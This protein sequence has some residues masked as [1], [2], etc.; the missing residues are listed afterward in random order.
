MNAQAKGLSVE[1]PMLYD[2]S[3]S[4]LS[5]SYQYLVTQIKGHVPAV[6]CNSK[7]PPPRM[8]R[9]AERKSKANDP[10][11]RLLGVRYD[12]Q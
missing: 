1:Q 3:I 2:T 4:I 12:S 6:T 7:P 9:L 11:F 5:W 8:K 10:Y